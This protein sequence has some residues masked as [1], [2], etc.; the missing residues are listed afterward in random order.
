M[1][2]QIGVLLLSAFVVLTVAAGSLWA[3]EVKKVD[4]NQATIEQLDTL[5]GIGPAIAKRIVDYREKNGPFKK[6]EDLMNVQGIGEKKFLQLKDL[7]I[8]QP[9]AP[10][11]A[12]K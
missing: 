4:L 2:Q 9:A 11:P 8:V 6:A 1:K 5:P 12:A 7:V 3:E 10:Q